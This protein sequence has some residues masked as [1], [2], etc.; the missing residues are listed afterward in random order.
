MSSRDHL[1]AATLAVHVA[2]D[3]V[4]RF[5]SST[6]FPSVENIERLRKQ[7]VSAQP[8]AQST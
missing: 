4:G 1:R 5:G 7:I 6:V 3:K 8:R 2:S